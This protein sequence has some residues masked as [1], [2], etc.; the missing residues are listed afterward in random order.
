MVA[1]FGDL[2]EET[3]EGDA[4]AEKASPSGVGSPAI[5]ICRVRVADVRDAGGEFVGEN[6]PCPSAEESGGEA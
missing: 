6:G 4:L 2:V 3:P 5:D 1:S